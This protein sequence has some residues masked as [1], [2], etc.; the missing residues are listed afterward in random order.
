[1]RIEAYTQ[2][3]QIYQQS[4]KTGKAQ[5]S[6]SVTKSSDKLQISTLGK[7]INSAKAAV[8]GSPDIREDVIAPIKARIQ[9]GTY[10]VS[11]EAFAEKLMLKYAEMR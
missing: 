8:A 11:V 4:Q 2:V 6:G 9:D 3:Q 1:M 5:Y 10:E 7:D